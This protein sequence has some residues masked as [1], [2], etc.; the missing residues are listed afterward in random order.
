MIAAE[1]EAVACAA[2][3]RLHPAPVG[4]DS[5]CAWIIKTPAMHRAPEIGVELEICTTPFA[6][7]RAEDHFKMFLRIRVRAVERVPGPTSPSA[8]GDFVRSQRLAVSI[9]DEPIG[10]LFEQM[11]LF[12]R[13]ERR[14]PDGRL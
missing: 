8:E 4:F 11:G 6:P 5:R 1:N 3:N 2:Q 14:D 13:D 7:H 9:F 10:M 12:F